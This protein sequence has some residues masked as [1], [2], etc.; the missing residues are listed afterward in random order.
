MRNTIIWS[1][2]SLVALA[3]GG[4]VT[5]CDGDAKIAKSSE[6]DSCTKTSDCNDGLRCID[7]TCSKTAPIVDTSNGGDGNSGGTPG[8]VVVAVVP[9]NLGKL[10]ESCTKRADCD[11][12]LACLS[13]RCSTG[14]D[15]GA[16]GQGSVGPALGGIGETCALTTDCADGLSCL[17]SYGYGEGSAFGVGVCSPVDNGLVATGKACVAEC[18]KP[19]DCCE[20]P[21]AVQVSNA[22]GPTFGIGVKSC[23]E[24]TTVLDGVNCDA[25]SL[26]TTNAARCFAQAAYCTCAK[27]TWACSDAGKC[28]YNAACTKSYAT[29]GGCPTYTR[30]G[31]AST[32]LCDVDGSG[33][34]QPAAPTATCKTDAT[35]DGEYTW[36]TDEICG[37]GEC[38][39]Y[40]ATSQCYR[41]CGE[42]LDC[43]VGQTCDTK[44][45]VCIQG[46]GCTNDAFC[47]TRDNNVNS[48]CTAA[49]VCEV[50]CNSDRDCNGGSLTNSTSTRVCSANHTCQLVGC[51]KDE[52]C[53]NTPGPGNVRMFCGT[54]STTVVAS[55]AVYSAITD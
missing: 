52:D 49:G 1:F 17:P 28:V 24:L 10:G 51:A 39:C 15:I 25:A 13:Q 53:I 47:V 12:G 46:P 37:A 55:D 48:K 41:K 14:A 7:A 20:L 45:K 18:S 27:N 3:T 26:T 4:L 33:K 6:G 2:L 30:A 21:V 22:S 43:A 9:P 16:G 32:P 11:D 31:V 50:S 29:P 40:K 36:D 34:C 19:D 38:T 42:D 35:C 5:G 8:V 23:A 44:T 54:V